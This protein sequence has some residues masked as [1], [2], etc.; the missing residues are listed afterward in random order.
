M[1]NYV[2]FITTKDGEIFFGTPQDE[3][4]SDVARRHNI[5]YEKIAGGGR[6]DLEGKKIYGTS[7]TFGS[8]DR[9]LVKQKL[10][11]WNVE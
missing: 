6:A 11:D 2:K 5:P 7:T 3:L 4:H 10:P 9:D 1:K 8:Y